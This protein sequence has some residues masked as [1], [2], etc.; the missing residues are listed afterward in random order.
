MDYELMKHIPARFHGHLEQERQKMQGMNLT[1][2]EA[3][4]KAITDKSL[5]NDVDGMQRNIG[6]VLSV[7]ASERISSMGSINLNQSMDG[8]L[9][10]GTAVA[11]LNNE[12]MLAVAQMAQGELEQ[13]LE[14]CSNPDRIEQIERMLN[15]HKRAQA[16]HAAQQEN[17][18]I[19]PHQF[20]RDMDNP[21]T[22][23]TAKPGNDT[24]LRVI[25]E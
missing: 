22:E 21:A 19:D 5:S 17:P 11:K 25:L 20:F 2:L 1:E 24:D 4:R 16:L 3:Y 14:T 23:S 18:S 15:S 10:L 6:S 13:E 9:D 12:Q 7:M 8:K